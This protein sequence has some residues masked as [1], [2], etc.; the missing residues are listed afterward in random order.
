MK[1]YTI[2]REQNIGAGH[3]AI[4]SNRATGEK[5]AEYGLTPGVELAEIAGLRRAIDRHL[6]SGGTLGNYHW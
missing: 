4:I 1:A 2:K 3:R 5:I 6:A